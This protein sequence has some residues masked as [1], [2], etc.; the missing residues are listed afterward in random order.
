MSSLV[1]PAR[2][3]RALL[4]LIGLLLVAA[5]GFAVA[6]HYG[7]LSLLAPEASLTPGTAFPAPWIWYAVAA[8]AVVL[9]LLLLRWLAA[10]LARKPKTHTW[11]LET[12]PGRGRTELAPGVAVAPFVDEVETYPGVH[13]AH[14]TLAGTHD[15]PALAI[16]VSAEQNTDLAVIRHRLETD[17]LPRLRRALDLDTVP[18]TIEFRFTTKSSARAS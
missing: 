1:R 7:L 6:T 13:A 3:N 14:A 8:G 4:G 11:R 12:D 2:L 10:Q 17:G 18:A 9:G 15:R 16:V 5:G